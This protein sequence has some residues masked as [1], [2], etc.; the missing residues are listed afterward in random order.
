MKDRIKPG[1]YDE[2]IE[3]VDVMPTLLELIGLPEPLSCQ[4]RSFAPL[5]S[6]INKAYTSHEEI[7]CENVIPE[8]ITNHGYDCEFKKG[9]GNMG[10]RHPDAK[11]I[12]TRRWKYNYY[13][14]Y[15][16]ELYDLHNDP[17]EQKNLFGDQ[18]YKSICEELKGRLLDWLITTSETDQIAPRWLI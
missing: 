7:F 18:K 1:R 9:V 12:R 13:P 8:V 17:L 15:D 4:G 11:M 3:T 2:L 14:D 5:I 6:Y 10:I 16:G